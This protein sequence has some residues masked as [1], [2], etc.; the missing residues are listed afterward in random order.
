MRKAE[1]MG[2]KEGFKQAALLQ[3]LKLGQADYRAQMTR[4]EA[5]AFLKGLN[6]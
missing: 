3:E 4:E 1:V 2:D 5:L 6:K